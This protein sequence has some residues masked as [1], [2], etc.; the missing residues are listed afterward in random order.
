MP[1]NP[2]GIYQP[3]YQGVPDMRQYQ[4]MQQAIPQQMQAPQQTGQQPGRIWVPNMQA[5]ND[6]LVA[7]NGAVDLWDMNAPVVYLKQADAS[8]RP[9]MRVFDLVERTGDMNAQRMQE[10]AP[11]YATKAE[12]EALSRKVEEL[13]KPTSKEEKNESFLQRDEPERTRSAQHGP[14]V[15]ELHE[16]DAG[17][18][19][20]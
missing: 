2:Y 20:A 4:P 3:I 11:Q 16:P 5:A 7:P 10:N 15:S 19:P 13:L 18:R 9:T 14:A 1:Y 6:Y 8:G 12:L 17:P